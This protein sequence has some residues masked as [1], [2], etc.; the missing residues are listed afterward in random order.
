MVQYL[1]IKKDFVT[2]PG[3][4]QNKN[5]KVADPK[6]QAAQ[7]SDET[8]DKNLK[9]DHSGIYN[10]LLHKF[11]SRNFDYKKTSRTHFP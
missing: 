9:L 4:L 5:H 6:L 2:F 10:E 8:N 7:I 3:P 11:F 1:K